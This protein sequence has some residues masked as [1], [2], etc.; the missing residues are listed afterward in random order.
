MRLL[1]SKSTKEVFS[2]YRV[3]HSP[4]TLPTM[5]HGQ[6]FLYYDLTTPYLDSSSYLPPRD[7]LSS[8]LGLSPGNLYQYLNVYLEQFKN[9]T[10]QE[11]KMTRFHCI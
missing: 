10:Y 6:A 7:A 4:N 2:V 9:T 11:F 3:W 8:S 1:F 5:I